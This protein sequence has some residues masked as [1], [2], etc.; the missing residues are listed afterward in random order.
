MTLVVE[1]LPG[2]S[3]VQ[4]SIPKTPPHPRKKGGKEGREGGKREGG[5]KEGGRK[6]KKK[7]GK[8]RNLDMC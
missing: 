7:G 5:G 1:C 6:G 4:S 2:K 3:K 8:E